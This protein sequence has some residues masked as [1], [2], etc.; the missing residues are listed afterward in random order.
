MDRF[1]RIFRI[2]SLL[3]N[4]CTPISLKQLMEQ[5]ECS[6]A[7]ADRDIKAL[8]DYL[9]APVEYNREL[10]GYIYNQQSASKPFELPGLWFSTEELHGL[11]ICQ[12]ILQ[13]I[14]PG[15]LSQQIDSL[16]NRINLMLNRENSRHPMIADKIQFTTV[17]RRLKDDS[18]FKRIA[19]ALLGDKQ[20]GINYIAR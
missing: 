7:T 13:N 9:N 4:R 2:H 11:L 16:Q 5:L 14:S 12:Q 20:I 3:K 6:K 17:G 18:Q 15:L 10:N 8:R 19:T 1:D